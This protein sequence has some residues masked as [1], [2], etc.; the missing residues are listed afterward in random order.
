MDDLK[1]KA[2]ELKPELIIGKNG[3]TEDTIQE[4]NKRINTRKLV[5]IK[6]LKSFSTADWKEL[7]E[8]LATRLK[9]KVVM[10]IGHTIVFH[11][12]KKIEKV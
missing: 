8:N 6:A 9:A 4:I 2:M 7:A 5:K 11:R 12:M 3:I 1:K 10:Q